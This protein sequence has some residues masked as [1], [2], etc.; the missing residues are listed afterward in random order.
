MSRMESRTAAPAVSAK[1]AVPEELRR[2]GE[3]SLEQLSELKLL[4]AQTLADEAGPGEAIEALQ[5]ALRQFPNFVAGWQQLAEWYGSLGDG[6]GLLEATERLAR[7][8]P[9]DSASLS[10]YGDALARAGERAQ[11]EQ[12]FALALQLDGSST[13]AGFWLFDLLFAEQRFADADRI[14]ERLRQHGVDGPFLFGR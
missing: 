8:K 13:F 7:L 10:A 6:T 3:I 2:V 9:D 1:A 14:L 11:A 12:N 4:E 5:A